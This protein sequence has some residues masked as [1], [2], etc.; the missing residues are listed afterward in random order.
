MV[1]AWLLGMIGPLRNKE[2]FQPDREGQL[3]W[4]FA[5]SKKVSAIVTIC[6][7]QSF[8]QMS[9]HIR[10]VPPMITERFRFHFHYFAIVIV[11]L[12]QYCMVS[13]APISWKKNSNEMEYIRSFNHIYRKVSIISAINSVSTAGTKLTLLLFVLKFTQFCGAILCNDHNKL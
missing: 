5:G 4:F 10:V 3:S 7:K 6:H 11:F 12:M 1:K 9:V 8:W 2:Y 13:L